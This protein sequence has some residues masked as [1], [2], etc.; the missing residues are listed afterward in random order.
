MAKV[1]DKGAVKA[2]KK[3]DAFRASLV[4]NG[5]NILSV[6]KVSGSPTRVYR[7]IDEN[8]NRFLISRASDDSF[9]LYRS[10]GAGPLDKLGELYR[11]ALTGAVNGQP[12]GANVRK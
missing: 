8:N 2:P 6:T 11:T 7:V 12:A 5:L 9:V 4:A 1:E 3:R 10:S